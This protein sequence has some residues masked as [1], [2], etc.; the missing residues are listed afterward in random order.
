MLAPGMNKA[1]LIIVLLV[2]PHS[3]LGQESTSAA[4]GWDLTYASVL[5][6]NRIGPDEWIRKWLGP[7]YQSPV[8]KLLSKW[9]GEPID[10]AI[11]IEHPAFH[12]GE[13]TTLWFVCTKSRA[14][15]VEMVEANPRHTLKEPLSLPLYDKLFALMSPWQQAQPRKPED[16]PKNALPGYIGFLSFY[17]RG[18]SRQMLLT[19]EDF[20]DCKDRNC[21]E[22]TLGRVYQALTILPRFQ[23]RGKGSPSREKNRRTPTR[24]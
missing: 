8:R 18:D 4:L 19:M 13:R 6:A 7:G 11:L 23:V 16:K 10:S 12:A 15:Y 14:Y 2:L 20:A 22:V 24:D 9:R 21:D 3:A 17:N 1:F 5:Y